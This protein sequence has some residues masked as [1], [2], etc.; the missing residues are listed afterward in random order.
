MISRREI[1]LDSVSSTQVKATN[2]SKV[3]KRT[4]QETTGDCQKCPVC[5]SVRIFDFVSAPDRFHLRQ[6]LYHLRRCSSCSCA[7]LACPPKSEEMPFHYGEDYHKAI[8][9]GGERSAVRRWQRHRELISRHKQGGALLDIG[10][11]SGGF[12]GTMKSESWTLYGIEMEA[13]T[14][15]KARLIAGAEVFVGDAMNAPFRPE[16]FDVVTCFDVLEHMYNPRQLLARVMEWLKPGGILYAK[17]PNIDSWEARLLGT[18]WYGLELPRHLYHFS[19][20]SLRRLMSTLGFQEVYITATEPGSHLSNSIRYVYEDFLKKLGL[21]PVSLAK[22]L[23]TTEPPSLPWRVARKAL[24][25]S[26]VAPLGQMAAAGGAG[27]FIDAIFRKG[28][29]CS[30]PGP[31]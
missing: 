18:Y 24:R 17:L 9:V 6:E 13:S 16:S 21:S 4:T 25:L 12:L 23:A 8:V 14:A 29:P 5:G 20:R 30:E 22:A 31:E 10:C 1:G 28:V 11:S 3:V 27:V 2:S 7:W 15:A 19:P 26:L